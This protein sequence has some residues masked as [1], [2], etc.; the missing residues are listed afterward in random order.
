MYQTLAAPV[1]FT[2]EE[3]RSEFI[4][5]L[6]PVQTREA[7][8]KH[9]EQLKLDYPNARHYCWAY[10]I[11]DPQQPKTAAFN[12]DGEPAGTA[13]KPIL[14]VLTQRGAGDTCAIVVRY[15][16]GIK[17]GAGGLV[18]A[19]GQSVS[20]T[21]DKAIWQTVIA[22]IT[23]HIHTN[24]EDEPHARHFIN[25]FEGEVIAQ[26]YSDAVELIIELAEQNAEALNK[27]LN[28]KTGGRCKMQNA[29]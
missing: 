19:Y 2:L 3:K 7:A 13:G 26:H 23:V 29:Q 20:Q 28:E 16:G 1:S 21:L 11:G 24:Y 8:L 17:L 9:L 6:F 12:D 10:L 27:A 14:H 5:H 18:R 4:C 25:Q 15:F 22:K